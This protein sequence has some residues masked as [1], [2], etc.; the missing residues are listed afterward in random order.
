MK[1]SELIFGIM[2]IPGDFLAILA[3]FLFAFWLRNAE[4]FSSTIGI[5]PLKLNLQFIPFLKSAALISL[6]WIAAFLLLGLYNPK[7]KKRG[8]DLLWWVFISISLGAMALFTISF[9]LKEEPLSSRFILIFAWVFSIAF[10]FLTRYFILYFQR[11]VYKYGIGVYRL[12]IV[13]QNGILDVLKNEAQ[14][15]KNLGYILVG[16]LKEEDLKESLAGLGEIKSKKGLDEIIHIVSDEK[17]AS[18]IIDFCEENRVRY[19]FVPNTFQSHSI[20]LEATEIANIPVL[21]VKKTPLDGWGRITKRLF[22]LAVSF[23]L[24][25]LLLPLFLVIAI[26][27]KLTDRGP[28]FYKHKRIGR[29]KKE[30]YVFKFRS[31]KA[32]YSTGEE[33]SGKSDEEILTTEFGDTKLVEEFK[34]NQKLKNDPRVSTVGKFLRKTS[35]DELPQLF[36]VFQGNMSLVGPRPVVEDELEKYGDHQ[37][38]LFEI[39]PGITG[40]WQTSGR[41]E[42]SYED[43]IRMDLFYIENWSLLLD[44]KIILKTIPA[45]LRKRGAY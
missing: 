16:N 7:V 38:H 8:L 23:L 21:E 39:K 45:I 19:R 15:N 2:R 28:V 29:D 18:K 26:T 5:T 44:I 37:Y 34:K 17:L 24:L 4:A 25:L 32:K 11:F 27:I 9:L 31:M 36:N 22:D 10:V 13:G 1:K 3:G 6:I 12:A 40:M 14:E 41:S 42:V 35:I 33:F 30:F 20:N 43:R